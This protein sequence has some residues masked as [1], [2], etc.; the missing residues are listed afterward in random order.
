MR[1]IF[2]VFEGGDGVGKSTQ[3][4]RLSAWLAAQGRETV[5]TFEPGDGPVNAQIRRILLSRD[6]AELNPRTEALLFA[7]D[8]AQ[9]VET[10]VQPAL[11]RGAMVVSDRYVDSTLAYQGAGRVLDAGAVAEINTWATGGLLPD[12]TV[13]LDLEPSLG[14]SAVTSQDRIEAAGDDFHARVRQGFLSLAARAPERYLVLPA[15]QNRDHIAAEVQ[16]RVQHLLV[17]RG[18]T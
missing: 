4:A 5:T 9:H 18:Q 14:V 10:V 7:A 16:A 1:G 3:V 13:L 17:R 6:T 8:R 2:V 15:R 11:R 12:L